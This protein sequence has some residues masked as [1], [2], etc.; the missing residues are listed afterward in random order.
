MCHPT[1]SLD[2]QGSLNFSRNNQIQD[3]CHSP[4]PPPKRKGHSQNYS[5]SINYTGLLTL[6]GLLS[7]NFL[8]HMPTSTSSIEETI[9]ITAYKLCVEYRTATKLKQAHCGGD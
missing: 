9:L 1:T 7:L 3:K 2:F 8:L 4:P 6:S 5:A